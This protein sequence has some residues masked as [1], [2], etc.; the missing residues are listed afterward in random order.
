MSISS[1]ERKMLMPL[2]RVSAP[3]APMA[4][5]TADSRRYQE[6]GTL[7]NGPPWEHGTGSDLGEHMIST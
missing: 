6:M 4:N 2:R 7:M 5:S 1:I 3:T